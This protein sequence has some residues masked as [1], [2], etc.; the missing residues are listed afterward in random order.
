MIRENGNKGKSGRPGME[1]RLL[2]GK[3]AVV[4]ENC[5]GW[6]KRESNHLLRQPLLCCR[7][8]LTV[9]LIFAVFLLKV[10]TV[11]VAVPFFFAFTFPESD[12]VAT[13]LLLDL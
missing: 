13:F 7:R 1:N 5:R 8:Y 2:Q 4:R 11:I 9:I 12:T 10:L 6:R 3:E